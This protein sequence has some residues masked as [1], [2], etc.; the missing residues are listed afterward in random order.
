MIVVVFIEGEIEDFFDE[1]R[2]GVWDKEGANI[3]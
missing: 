1:C 3:L 2:T